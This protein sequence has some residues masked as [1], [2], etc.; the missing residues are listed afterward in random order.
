MGQA[1]TEALLDWGKGKKRPR[2]LNAAT[3]GC[4]AKELIH[5]RQ[6]TFRSPQSPRRIH[7]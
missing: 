5:L 1:G 4:R 2:H 3:H 6:R 7:Q